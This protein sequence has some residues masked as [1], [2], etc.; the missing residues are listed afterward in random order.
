MTRF[1][2]T[3]ASGMLGR[4]LQVAL[5]GRD[6]VALTRGQLDITDATAVNHAVEGID[7]VINAAAYTRVDDAETHQSEAYA[8]NAIGAGNVATAAAATGATLVQISTDY[9]FDGTAHTPYGEHRPRDPVS[10]YGRSKAEGERL[11]LDAHPEAFIV[12]T[13]WLY[14]EHGPNFPKTMLRLANERDTVDVV[15]DQYGQ[16]TWSLDLATAI[17]ELV[18][19]GASTDIYHVTNSGSTTWYELAR[20]VFELAGHDPGRVV[21]T[22]S[23]RFVRPAPRPSYSVLGHDAWFEAGLTPMRDWRDALRAAFSTG[24]LAAT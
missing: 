19:S 7:V 24:A 5:A 9:V 22:E 18:D 4:D 15:N 16:P 23:S 2:V 20:A 3:G 10:V 6:V 21:P 12:R 17:V 1:L 13:A 8:I 14:G 11:V